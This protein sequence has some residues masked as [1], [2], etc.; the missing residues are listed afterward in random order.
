MPAGDRWI[1][2]QFIDRAKAETGK[3][4]AP[5]Y[6]FA[7][8]DYHNIVW[9]DTGDALELHDRVV[10]QTLADKIRPRDTQPA[11]DAKRLAQ[12]KEGGEIHLQG[13]MM[14]SERD[15]K[16]ARLVYDKRGADHF[17][18]LFQERGLRVPPQPTLSDLIS[19]AGDILFRRTVE[20]RME[21]TEMPPLARDN[22]GQAMD[23]LQEA[24]EDLTRLETMG[25]KLHQG[26]LSGK[27]YGHFAQSLHAYKENFPLLLD[28]LSQIRQRPDL[29]PEQIEA[30]QAVETRAADAH[31]ALA[32]LMT[33]HA[34]HLP[35]APP[36]SRADRRGALQLDAEAMRNALGLMAARSPEDALLQESCRRLDPLLEAH[37]ERLGRVSA[38]EPPDDLALALR[39]P[40]TKKGEAAS[41]DREALKSRFDEAYRRDA[42]P[43]PS[44]HPRM[45]QEQMLS[46]FVRH[47]MARDGVDAKTL[48]NLKSL[49][50]RGR[51]QA[52][53]EK[54]WPKIEREILCQRGRKEMSF[55]SVIEPAGLLS[56]RLSDPYLGRGIVASDR[57]QYKHAVNLA[58]SKL[59][60]EKGEL[61]YAGHR[62]GVLDPYEMTPKH[63]AGLSDAEL[64]AM[65]KDLVIDGGLR[66]E[67]PGRL[68]QR[69]RSSLAERRRLSSLMRREGARRQARDLAAT[70][71]L[72]DP[73]KLKMAMQGETVEMPITSISL[74]TPD[75][76]RRLGKP[77]GDEQT[78]LKT[79]RDALESLANQGK[80]ITVAIRNQHGILQEARMRVRPRILSFGVNA[81][82][83]RSYKKLP[84][85]RE[86]L[87]RRLMGWGFSAKMNDP[88]LSDL[89]GKR[90]DILLGGEV[91][92]EIGAS[93]RRLNQMASEL[94]GLSPSSA[95]HGKRRAALLARMEGET[96]RM[97][98]LHQLG[99]QTKQ[100]WRDA[101]YLEEGQDPYDMVAR[102][103]ALAFLL[104]Q[105]PVV[106]CKSGKDRTGALDSAVKDLLAGAELHGS[107][108]QPGI[109]PD[110][111]SRRRRAAFNLRAGSMEMQR[112][113]TGL[114]GYKTEG[115]PSL[116]KLMEEQAVPV[117][118]G[119][120]AFVKG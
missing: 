63:L 85:N 34:E 26:K 90:G 7:E 112:Y 119:G 43:M 115:V 19:D 55:R 89:L 47:E 31:M 57:L 99:Q 27:D 33:L 87:F 88:V 70:M 118:R 44:L 101:S 12:T 95:N 100:M 46:L 17:P 20:A 24:R 51:V 97:E 29:T 114:P 14:I 15:L 1:K 75:Y 8:R 102:L 36:L 32:D 10:A 18:N 30:L 61:L 64:E 84:G 41:A 42:P 23:Y 58:Q 81:G 74:M 60:G 120:S 53:E 5:R 66:S 25:A 109:P 39:L 21:E 54:P 106:N 13:D 4:G 59:Y 76:L 104:G 16:L 28:Y 11:P 98:R 73:E 6:R 2:V 69:F 78:M 67:S 40:L 93:R 79:Q 108:H 50:E 68:V 45:T 110:S 65:M 94:A 91:A 113:N 83:L 56:K 82:A 37:G 96:A 86:P 72:N 116:M 49:F 62:M 117:Y 92:R 38:D 48:G 9:R 105:K 107:V 77:A 22:L 111:E 103:S 3:D 52:M 35:D 71:L 80:P